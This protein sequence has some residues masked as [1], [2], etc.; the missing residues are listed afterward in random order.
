MTGHP[1]KQHL[2]NK[3][4]KDRWI[5]S[6][7]HDTVVPLWGKEICMGKCQS[8]E[9]CQCLLPNQWGHLPRSLR[10]V[11]VA[12]INYTYG[13]DDHGRVCKAAIGGFHVPANITS[14]FYFT[15][16]EKTDHVQFDGSVGPIFCW[17]LA[18]DRTLLIRFVT[19]VE[20]KKRSN[21]LAASRLYLAS[22]DSWDDTAD[23]AKPRSRSKSA[24]K[25]IE[26][27]PV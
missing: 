10:F 7:L 26:I 22:T 4:P 18:N 21:I 6:C 15:V 27:R 12:A 9:A 3:K 24:P 25:R 23:L 2:L 14:R 16:K 5:I 17:Y 20:V 8:Q 1:T 11:K 19:S 13:T